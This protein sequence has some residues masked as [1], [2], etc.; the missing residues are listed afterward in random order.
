MAKPPPKSR[1][2][3]ISSDVFTPDMILA[4]L[5]QV[6]NARLSDEV[7]MAQE[8][9]F[10]AWEAENPRRRAALARKALKVSEDCADAW[11]LLAQETAVTPKAQLDLLH[12][13][14]AA[15]ERA[16][17]PVAFEEDVGHFWGLIETRP[18]MRA[19][20]ALAMA[21]WDLGAQ[22]EAADHLGAMIRLNP[23]DNQGVRYVLMS[24]LLILDRLA[25]LD[26]LLKMFKDPHDPQWAFPAAL[27]AFRRK[28]DTAPARK[29]LA[30]ALASNPHVAPFLTRKKKLPRE[31]PPWYAPGD[32]NEAVIYVI[33]AG[34][35]ESWATTPGALAWLAA[36]AAGTP[37]GP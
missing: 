33:D 28:G 27:V 1:A 15:G 11:L 21:L 9:M 24:W 34:G 10:D 8:I 20:H 5:S 16:L 3:P 4:M 18:Y 26:A 7:D 17:G 29:A 2:N 6:D 22:A 19:R 31:M 37:P 14:V 36:Q 32:R 35:L 12:K 23:N 25:D 30:N 13:A